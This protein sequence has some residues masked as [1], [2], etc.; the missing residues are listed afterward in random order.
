MTI[1]YRR[2]GPGDVDQA[3]EFAIKGLRPELYPMRLSPAKID[4][5]IQH[6]MHSTSDF[7]MAA[8]DG[9]R[10][11]GGIAAAVYES[12][13]FERCD[14]TVVMCQAIVPG[15]GRKLI[16]MLKAW[17]DD[18]FRVRRV[19]FPLEFDADARMQR[20]LARYGFGSTQVVCTYQKD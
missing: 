11:V 15:V 2:I 6:F 16:A 3:A 18:D 5:T 13:W 20:L 19:M 10:I 17:A 14:A 9:P 8:F 12:A 7:H 1:E 4:A